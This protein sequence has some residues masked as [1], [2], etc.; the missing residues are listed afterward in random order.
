TEALLGP[1]QD[2]AGKRLPVPPT[3]AEHCLIRRR[4]CEEAD[5]P[6]VLELRPPRVVA[7]PGG[8]RGLLVPIARALTGQH[9]RGGEEGFRGRDVAVHLETEPA[10]DHGCDVRG[11]E[12]ERLLVITRGAFPVA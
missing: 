4:R 10:A 8:E 6:T 11:F 9:E 2:D 1:E 7:P 5:P 12:S 3:V